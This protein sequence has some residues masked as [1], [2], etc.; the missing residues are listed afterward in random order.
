MKPSSVYRIPM[1]RALAL[2][3]GAVAL[4]AAAA[5]ADDDSDSDLP[6]ARTEVRETCADFNPLRIPYF[7]ETHIHTSLS[8]D[9]FGV[10]PSENLSALFTRFGAK[11]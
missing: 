11:I 7:G 1:L 2:A 4:L 8:F 6:F 5:S 9:A 10:G 3:V